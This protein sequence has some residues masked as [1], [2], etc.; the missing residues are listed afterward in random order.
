MG[1]NLY[2]PGADHYRRASNRPSEMTR[3]ANRDSISRSLDHLVGA[4]LERCEI[5]ISL[6]RST[7]N[8]Q[9]STRTPADYPIFIGPAS[10]SFISI[11]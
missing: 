2:P 9:L 7:P 5:T 11:A 4:R 6:K 8:L 10:Q 1:L 3:S